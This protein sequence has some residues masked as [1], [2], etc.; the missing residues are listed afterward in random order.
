LKLRLARVVPFASTI[1]TVPWA[2]S[3]V[4]KPAFV[5]WAVSG[6]V[7]RYPVSPACTAPASLKGFMANPY[8]PP[9]AR[10]V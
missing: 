4:R 6:G 2:A 8:V 10:S 1:E 7:K 3:T 5:F 9:S